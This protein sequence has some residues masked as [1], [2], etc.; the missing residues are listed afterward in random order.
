MSLHWNGDMELVGT[1]RTTQVVPQS[2][3]HDFYDDMS[4]GVCDAAVLEGA[5]DQTGIISPYSDNLSQ[6]DQYT[7]FGHPLNQSRISRFSV[8]TA[9]L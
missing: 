8:V 1:R 5:Q 4:S 3:P 9:Q 2:I 6:I 7:S